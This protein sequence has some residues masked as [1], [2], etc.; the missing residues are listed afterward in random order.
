MEFS[1]AKPIYRELKTGWFSDR[2]AGNLAS[3]RR[4]AVA[5]DTGFSEHLPTGREL[6][7]FSAWKTPLVE[8]RRSTELSAAHERRARVGGRISQCRK[9]A[10]L[11]ARRM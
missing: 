6:L 1:R 7:R 10:A 5:E 8:Q 9:M 4:R 11:H 2:S 3:G